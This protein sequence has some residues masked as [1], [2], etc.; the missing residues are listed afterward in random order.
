MPEPCRSSRPVALR[1]LVVVCLAAAAQGHVA[2]AQEPPHAVV[3]IDSIRELRAAGEYAAALAT[4][5]DMLA[6]A[7]D[8]AEPV[9]WQVESLEHLVRTLETVVALPDARRARLADADRLRL[10]N[11]A[12]FAADEH[13]RAADLAREELPLR[14]EI[15]GASHLEVADV[16][17]D[18]GLDLDRAWADPEAGEA[19]YRRCLEIRRAR[20]SPDHPDV[21][22]A[23]QLLGTMLRRRDSWV[24]AEALMR[25]GLGIRRRT[26]GD[27]HLDT[28]CSKHHLAVLLRRFSRDDE[29]EELLV[30]AV[31]VHR[32]QLTYE[33]R[34][35]PESLIMLGLVY[36]AEGRHTDAE[37][38]F[39]EALELT[40]QRVG[41]DSW[42]VSWAQVYVAS[43]LRKQKRYADADEVLAESEARL[44]PLEHVQLF[45]VLRSRGELA[46][47]VRDYPKAV[48]FLTEALEWNRKLRGTDANYHIVTNLTMLAEARFRGGDAAGALADL[49][50][51]VD[52]YEAARAR[53]ESGFNRARFAHTPHVPL[54][55]A[56]LELGRTD[57]AWHAAES[58]RGRV[59]ADAVLPEG[60]TGEAVAVF[61]LAR[62]QSSLDRDTAIV[63]WLDYAL[64]DG[65]PRFWGYVIRDS[66]PVRW[67]RLDDLG[68]EAGADVMSAPRALR[69]RLNAYRESIAGVG[70]SALGG[71]V[72][73]P[74]L[75]DEM[76]ALGQARFAPLEA[77]L[78]G[79]RRLVI[80]SSWAMS[81]VPVQTFESAS[82]ALVGERYTTSYAPS[83]T[84]HAR[85]VETSRGGAG[86]PASA[87]LVGDPPFR[88]EHLAEAE[89]EP[90]D[91]AVSI[92]SR[93]VLR[94]V[95]EGRR[96]ALARL[97]R[98]PWSRRE[99]RAIAARVERPS[100]LLGADASKERLDALASSGDLGGFDLVHLATH[101]V[102]DNDNPERSALVLAQV[103]TT[104]DGLLTAQDIMSRWRLGARLVTLSA[105][106]TGLGENLFGE[107]IVGF[108]YTFFRAGAESVLVS[109]W[110]VDDRATALL[111]DRFY[112]DWLGADGRPAL[113]R[114]E[115][116]REATS[117]LRDYESPDGTRPYAHPYFW[118]GFVLVGA[119]G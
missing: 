78:R 73:D 24:E 72:T 117:W 76:R 90:S 29:A 91:R 30:S 69:S 48:R 97:P 11:R 79:V 92:A 31:A 42:Y 111:M 58:G 107:G 2:R 13:E 110:K 82:G 108:A 60:S 101:A 3:Q 85:L 5:R 16:L 103:G 17:C 66:G 70:E 51:A 43:S 6:T 55:V 54:A 1:A 75:R 119:P 46:L 37:P 94:G 4:A 53:V 9:A 113:G 71:L 65:S 81:G 12:A 52:A 23:Y 44:R 32:A 67:V 59:L 26:L 89:L 36:Q 63:G 35:L 61:D 8:A 18:L 106:E 83:A 99:V 14:E 93:S 95:V 21:G 98:L 84:V 88:P 56:L 104:G 15:L 80:V 100:L 68:I 62:V 112:D 10:E 25:E 64:L 41:E 50:T 19:S 57:E 118:S 28:A 22:T 77:H 116:L 40:R 39:R 33:S 49:E 86:P 115:A 47:T 34:L 102:M 109:L 38:L 45:Q 20:L 105:C 114:A 96:D 87:L 27:D 74:S 7:R